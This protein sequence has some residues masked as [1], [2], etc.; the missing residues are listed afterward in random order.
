MENYI[1]C[2]QCGLEVKEYKQV[3]KPEGQDD[4]C[5][6]CHIANLAEEQERKDNKNY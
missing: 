5:E 2:R 3:Q 1:S 4:I 6:F